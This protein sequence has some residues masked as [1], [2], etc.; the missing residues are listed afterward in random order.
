MTVVLSI[1]NAYVT[2]SSIRDRQFGN[3]SR[4][5]TV[6][7]VVGGPDGPGSHGIPDQFDRLMDFGDLEVRQSLAEF[8]SHFL[9]L[10]AG[11]RRIDRPDQCD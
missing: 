1:G 4:D 9:Q 2:H 6:R 5:A 11:R 10:R 8:A 3:S 7:D